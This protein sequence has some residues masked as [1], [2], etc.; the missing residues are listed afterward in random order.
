MMTIFMLLVLLPTVSPTDITGVADVAAGTINQGANQVC[1][2]ATIVCN[3]PTVDKNASYICPD[4]QFLRGDAA[5]VCRTAAQI[6][7]D[8][9][10]VTSEVYLLEGVTAGDGIIASGCTSGVCTLS[11]DVSVIAGTELYDSGSE[12]LSMVS[13]YYGANGACTSGTTTYLDG[14]GNCDDISTVYLAEAGSS[15]GAASS[16]FNWNSNMFHID[17]NN[18]KVAIGRDP[19]TMESKFVIYSDKVAL[20]LKEDSSNTAINKKLGE[21]T[22]RDGSKA[23]AAI[24]VSRDAAGG[25]SD[26]PTRISFH[27]TPDGSSTMAERMRITNA[28]YVGIGTTSPAVALDINGV[29]EADG[30]KDDD[31]VVHILQDLEIKDGLIDQEATDLHFKTNGD[32][33]DYLYLTTSSNRP[34]I[35]VSGGSP[36]Y[37]DPEG[38]QIYIG[39]G[40]IQTDLMINDGSLVTSGNVAAPSPS[41][42]NGG[43]EIEG[44]SVCVGNSGCT[45][46]TS[47]G[48]LFVEGGISIDTDGTFPVGAGDFLIGDGTDA[49]SGV[50]VIGS[51][52]I[53][54]NGCST[55]LAGNVVVEGILQVAGTSAVTYHRFGSSGTGHSLSGGDDVLISGKL[56]V[57][58][59]I[60]FDGG[61]PGDIAEVLNSKESILYPECEVNAH[62]FNE[63]TTDNILF[64]D[65]VCMSDE[66]MII[67]KCEGENNKL[68]AGVVSDTT[69]VFIGK[70]SGYPIA[71]AGLVR[72]KV[73]NENGNI[74]PG[75]LL[76]TSSKPGFAMKNNDGKPGTI[77]GEA[78]DFCNKEECKIT[79]FVTMR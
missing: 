73:T 79:T 51:M 47:N 29:I 74:K 42:R 60:Y 18:N 7:S 14:E 19:A 55:P 40:S 28:G 16:D 48:I 64:G 5:G 35:S 68:V 49:A 12:T 62:C 6:A 44:G 36:I 78:F 32:T 54:T 65:V 31:G 69:K 41:S 77:L 67:Q 61:G 9:G 38:D 26:Y 52:C 71:V 37:I 10:A 72:T 1:D 2:D 70:E 15:G 30:L 58:G 3:W 45:P 8:A 21:I 59:L 46:P 4:G 33:D 66:E 23:E 39:D 27:T 50:N 20:S 13:T 34:T 11:V 22:W 57:D 75:D 43:L 53:G 25:A 63:K 76:V 17:V 56:E 24:E